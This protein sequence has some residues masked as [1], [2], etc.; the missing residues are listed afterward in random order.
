MSQSWSMG[1]SSI[2]I[3]KCQQKVSIS[4]K[5]F[6]LNGEDQRTL[7][8]RLATLAG[9][10]DL[11]DILLEE[12][13]DLLMCIKS[14]G[15]S[16][17][18]QADPHLR[19][20]TER[21]SQ[22]SSIWHGDAEALQKQHKTAWNSL[23]VCETFWV[24]T[25]LQVLVRT[26]ISQYALRMAY[27]PLEAAQVIMQALCRKLSCWKNGHWESLGDKAHTEE[28]NNHCVLVSPCIHFHVLQCN[29]TWSSWS[30]GWRS[31]FWGSSADFS[32]FRNHWKSME[33]HRLRGHIFQISQWSLPARCGS[34]KKPLGGSRPRLRIWSLSDTVQQCSA[35]NE[36]PARSCVVQWR[37][38]AKTAEMLDFP[39]LALHNRS[40]PSE[41]RTAR[42]E[43]WLLCGCSFRAS[44]PKI[45]EFEGTKGYRQQER[46]RRILQ[47]ST[48]RVLKTHCR[49]PQS[50][51]QKAAQIN[52]NHGK[53]GR[54]HGGLHYF[55]LLGSTSTALLS[56]CL[57]R[58][59]VLACRCF[60]LTSS[61]TEMID[62]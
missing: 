15:C 48:I 23:K 29:F 37:R 41:L 26:C 61:V 13:S 52:A 2:S 39:S 46:I 11:V 10:I 33:S 54:Q 22:S 3:K 62:W 47:E 20:R 42:E 51:M 8:P 55:L 4:F 50:Q 35:P 34:C 32:P 17:Q 14:A 27:T 58:L 44:T 6:N 21:A 9:N 16:G 5:C 60:W 25:F 49:D 45:P 19:E 59:S 18:A 31:R 53:A 57:K 1:W 38:S 28:C 12:P 40:N 24:L 30:G 56:N 36:V 7:F 43:L